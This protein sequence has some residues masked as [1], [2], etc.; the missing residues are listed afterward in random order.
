MGTICPFDVLSPSSLVIFRQLYPICRQVT[1]DKC[2]PNTVN[3]GKTSKLGL[4]GPGP[5]MSFVLFGPKQGES[6]IEKLHFQG[7]TSKSKPTNTIKLGKRQ[8]DKSHQFHAC[9][10]CPSEILMGCPN[11]RPAVGGLSRRH[12]SHDVIF[13]CQGWPQLQQT[14]HIV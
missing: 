10:G 14:Y 4:F 5:S 3:V 9:T 7:S 11:R 6:G 2:V 1:L 13:S 8:K 12:P